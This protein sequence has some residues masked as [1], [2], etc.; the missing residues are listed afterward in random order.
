[1]LY[2]LQT[3]IMQLLAA[4][5]TIGG[6]VPAFGEDAPP[7]V[8]LSSRLTGDVN[9]VVR[10]AAGTGVRVLTNLDV[11][12][13][14]DLGTLLAWR[15]ARV[16]LHVLDNRGGD[17][18]GLAGTLQGVDNIEVGRN[19]TKLYQAWIEQDLFGGK[20]ALL[21]GLA[22]LN[23]DFYQD[24]S[25]GVLLAPAFGIGSEL[26]ATG[27]NGPS[28]FPSTALTARLR[29][30]LGAHGYVKG[31]VVD[32]KSGV[33]GDPGGVDWR[34]RE[35]ALLIGEAGWTGHG[36][37]AVGYWR[38][39]KRQED[40]RLIGA[41]GLP[42]KAVSEGAYLLI[43]Q[44]VTS[45]TARGPAISLFARIGL[46]DGATTPFRGGWQFGTLVGK[47]FP[48][49]PNSQFSIGINR[50]QLSERYRAN[51]ADAQF[52][53]SHGET[54]VEATYSDQVTPYLRLQPDLQYVVHPSGNPAARDAIIVGLRIVFIGSKMI[55]R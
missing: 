31:A 54:G 17:P 50:G 20:A 41:N 34:M 55:S 28:I 32:A 42:A 27:P 6:A 16:K 36:K 24:D 33:L 44:P 45:S 40:I 11:V 10:G 48:S 26:A 3:R 38:Y 35:G 46:S 30:T 21:L 5:L 51:S 39:T 15:G 49:R 14:V 23:A 52:T 4:S 22:D 19:R 1:M 47:V 13:V 53:L 8:V 43:D 29:V 7:S 9:G 2:N 37:V 25:A 12:A 18:N